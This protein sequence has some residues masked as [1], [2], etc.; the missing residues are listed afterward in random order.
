MPKRIHGTK[1]AAPLIQAKA[2][3]NSTSKCR[4]RCGAFCFR[5]AVNFC[6][7]GKNWR[8]MKHQAQIWHQ[9]DKTLPFGRVFYVKVMQLVFISHG[10]AHK[11][12]QT[13]N[14][15]VSIHA[16]SQKAAVFLLTFVFPLQTAIRHMPKYM[17]AQKRD[18]YRRSIWQGV[19][20]QG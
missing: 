4:T 12:V 15:D 19:I 20:R 18:Y 9:S 16:L 5:S 7:C 6:A 17:S 1:T 13:H 3:L 11:L 2:R 14:K 10:Q 8:N